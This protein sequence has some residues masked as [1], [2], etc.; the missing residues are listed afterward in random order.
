M[1]L[2]LSPAP[3][4]SPILPLKLPHHGTHP[5]PIPHPLVC[6]KNGRAKGIHP[7]TSFASLT[8]WPVSCSSW[9]FR[10]LLW[11]SKGVTNASYR[12]GLCSIAQPPLVA[13]LPTLRLPALSQVVLSL[14]WKGLLGSTHFPTTSLL[15]TWLSLRWAS[16]AYTRTW[17]RLHWTISP[18]YRSSSQPTKH[19]AI[20]CPYCRIQVYNGRIHTVPW[21]V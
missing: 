11:S 19:K 13:P 16:P 14:L 5:H 21:T 9:K 17:A 4:F 20:A 12:V 10:H 15:M 7:S 3:P 8:L 6:A 18:N 1:W 2:S